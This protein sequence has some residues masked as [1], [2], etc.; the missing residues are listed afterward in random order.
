MSG[1]LTKEKERKNNKEENTRGEKRAREEVR[2]K[3][4][5][6]SVTALI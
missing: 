4:K 3:K 1:V 2:D 5:G 6:V